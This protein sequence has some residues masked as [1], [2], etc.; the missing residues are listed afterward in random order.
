MGNC[1]EPPPVIAVLNRVQDAIPCV[2]RGDCGSE[3]A[4]TRLVRFLQRGA[5]QLQKGK[6]VSILGN[7]ERSAVQYG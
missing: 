1:S 5:E 2:F 6:K 3:A 4:M 7:S